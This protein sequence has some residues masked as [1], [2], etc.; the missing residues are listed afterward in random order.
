MIMVT[1]HKKV[2]DR[3]QRDAPGSDMQLSWQT[4][5]G[6]SSAVAHTYNLSTKQLEA[7]GSQ[8]LGHLDRELVT[9]H[10]FLYQGIGWNSRVT[11]M[12]NW[13]FRCRFLKLF[14]PVTVTFTFK[15][16]V[17]NPKYVKH[18]YALDQLQVH[19][20]LR[21]QRFSQTPYLCV[22]YLPDSV[23]EEDLLS[24]KDFCWEITIAEGHNL[25]HGRL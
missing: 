20:K 22:P 24:S 2:S 11:K 6:S 17:Q 25:H 12:L 3:S 21:R 10:R 15:S 7:G 9:N 18:L 14:T 1:Q 23:N 13:S 5:P 4:V 19:S 8:V 16:C